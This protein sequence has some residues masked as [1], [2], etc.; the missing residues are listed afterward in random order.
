MFNNKLVL[1]GLVAG[2]FLLPVVA[3]A[4]VTGQCSNCH[5]M[6]ASQDGVAAATLNAHLLKGNSTCVGC[7]TNNGLASAPQVD[8]LT[9]VKNAGYF[10]AAGA[11]NTLHNVTT[12]PAG[13]D[14][15]MAG[16]VPGSGS[17]YAGF[18]LSCEKCHNGSGGHH[19]TS[20]NTYR[21]IP[22]NSSSDPN[23]GWGAN[24]GTFPGTRADVAY[25]ATDMNLFCARC[26]GNFHTAANQGAVGAWV[27]HPTD[28][29]VSTSTE[30]SID[31]TYAGTNDAVPL[32]SD[33]TNTD[34]VM[35]LSCHVAHGGPYADL[36]SFD[37][38][39][40]SAGSGTRGV[41]C[42]SCHG[43]AAWGN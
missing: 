32:G 1:G 41:G 10:N 23:T 12:L 25:S 4:A 16:N 3:G 42:E 22:S 9:V 6:H 35:C 21:L 30:M 29:R 26:H 33:G 38:S 7:H 19:G 20:A 17:T 36:L 15:N 24:G 8:S 13:A 27:R 34:V 18:N 14:G 28:V 43:A 37:Y 31:T 40:N 2:A 11:D 39:L 5:T